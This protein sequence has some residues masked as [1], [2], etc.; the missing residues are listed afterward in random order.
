MQMVKRMVGPGAMSA[1]ALAR[2]VG[3]SQPTLSQWLR[4][5]NRVAAMTPPPEEKKPAGPK[6]WTPEEKLRVLAEAHGLEGEAL[7]ALLRREG[8][9]EEQLA[10][11]R[12]AAAGA[13]SQGVQ[14]AASGALTASQRRRLASSEKRV[15][16]LER[17]LLSRTG[18]MDRVRVGQADRPGEL[19]REP[20]FEFTAVTRLGSAKRLDAGV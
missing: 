17:E 2:Q 8:L 3:V 1:A 12:A 10:E 9:H 20:L 18:G 15:K 13:L 7:G 19:V 14:A 6:K 4:E 11:W 16:E 5:A